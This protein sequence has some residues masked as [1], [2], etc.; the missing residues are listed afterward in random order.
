MR[1]D[2]QGEIT[3]QTVK[4]VNAALASGE[5]LE[6]HVDSAGGDLF[7]GLGIYNALSSYDQDV[8]IYI[9]NVASSVASVI[10]LAGKHKPSIAP[11]GTIQIHNAHVAQATGNHN[12]LRKVANSLEKYSE[13][14]AM[15]YAKKT[16]QPIE[17]I[18]QA[19]NEE[20][21]FK[22]DEARAFGLAG[23]IFNP[24]QAFAYFETPIDMKLIDKIKAKMEALA[25]APEGEI[26]EE[27][28][29][30]EATPDAFTPE[31]LE[32][33]TAIVAEMVAQAL[34]GQEEAVGNVIATVF[35]EIKSE[36][37]PQRSAT[38]DAPNAI[39]DSPDAGVTAFYKK[40]NEIKTKNA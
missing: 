7:A 31:Q 27:V 28:T 37:I 30:E 16:G 3:T 2:I 26:V 11:H 39:N 5:A 1:L 25:V 35:N 8:N 20:T 14:V 13:V 33:I 29:T 36:G 15:I 22:A 40:I 12:D 9:D 19:M 34:A 23:D 21:T 17:D 10:A 38:I 24:I 18:L 4:Q 6:V 32:A